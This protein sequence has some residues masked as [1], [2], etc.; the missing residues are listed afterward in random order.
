MPTLHI[1]NGSSDRGALARCL[2]AASRGDTVLLIGNGV[3]LADAAVFG[4]FRSKGTG[5]AWFVL[6]DDV[7]ARSLTDRLASDVG[8]VDDEGFVDLVVAHHPIVSWS[9]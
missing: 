4:N 3:Y 5:F 8:L 7:R 9:A 2:Y 6:G 1:I